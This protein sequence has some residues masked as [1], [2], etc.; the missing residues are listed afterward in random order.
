MRRMRQFL[1]LAGLTAL[2]VLRQPLVLLLATAC[3]VCTALVPLIRLHPFGEDG[4]LARDSGLALH[5][6]FGLFLVAAAAGVALG[7]EVRRGTAAAVLAKPVGRTLFFLAKYAG[8]CAAVLAFS[9]AAAMATLLAERV[10]EHFVAAATGGSQFV[11]DYRTGIL[12][13]AA[14]AAAH[15]F[16]AFRNYRSRRPFGSAGF[17]GLLAALA[18]VLL[19]AG[20][21][22]TAGRFAPFDCRVPWR[23]LPASLLVA[24]ALLV[25]AAL[26]LALSTRWGAAP[27]GAACAAVF[28]AGLISD[29]AFGRHADGSRLAA[30]LHGLLPNWQHFWVCD[31]LSAG[32]AIPAAYVG[33][34]VLY[35]AAYAGGILAFGALSFRGAEIR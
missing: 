3:V 34:A 4:K 28:V 18:A 27:T 31:A 19:A 10:G 2:E 15:L 24:V 6:V 35:G 30:L 16:A 20:F 11:T 29:Y 13:L 32:G 9:A 8:V 23:V 25:M 12:L 1:G 7:R 17:G 5:F 21:Y 33:Q 14:P 22:D 26:A